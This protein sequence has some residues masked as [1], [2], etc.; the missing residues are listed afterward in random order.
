MSFEPRRSDATGAFLCMTVLV[1]MKANGIPLFRQLPVADVKRRAEEMD[2]EIPYEK[3]DV[4]GF[5]D[6]LWPT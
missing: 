4:R 6:G 2:Q 1:T 3:T 5:R